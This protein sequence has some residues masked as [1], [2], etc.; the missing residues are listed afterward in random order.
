MDSD[1][2]NQNDNGSAVWEAE[3][4]DD[5]EDTFSN[6]NLINMIRNQNNLHRHG[7]VHDSYE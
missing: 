3:I 5:S 1:R 6:H 4:D 2:F 7:G